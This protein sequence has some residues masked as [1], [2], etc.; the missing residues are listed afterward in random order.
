MQPVKA[1][2]PLIFSWDAVQLVV[3]IRT[4]AR[5]AQHAG[6]AGPEARRGGYLVGGRRWSPPSPTPFLFVSQG[7]LLVI[8]P[9]L[10][11]FVR[12]ARVALAFR[13]YL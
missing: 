12:C 4:S 13:S 1:A 2:P 9:D 7:L 10:L 8:F 3:G 5:A 6:P 11:T